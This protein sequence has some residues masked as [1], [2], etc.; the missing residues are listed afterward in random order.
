METGLRRVEEMQGSRPAVEL[1]SSGRASAPSTAPRRSIR[2]PSFSCSGS[3]EEAKQLDAIVLAAGVA[4]FWQEEQRSYHLHFPSL[5][6][7][8]YTHASD[9]P[10]STQMKANYSW[11]MTLAVAGVAARSGTGRLASLLGIA[12]PS[13][14]GVEADGSLEAVIFHDLLANIAGCFLMG[15]CAGASTPWQYQASWQY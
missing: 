12:A 7:D 2:R 6:Y 14:S 13:P 1:G 15:A 4:T 9:V 11:V 8:T 5:V 10:F 3:E